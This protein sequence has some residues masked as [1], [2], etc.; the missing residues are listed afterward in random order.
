MSDFVATL[1]SARDS[2]AAVLHEFWTLYD[3]SKP[4]VHAFFEGH[5]DV[6]F[7]SHH[8]EKR[9]PSAM[10]LKTY[11]CNSKSRVF[12]AFDGIMRAIPDAKLTLFFVDKDLDD[13]LGRAW[14][15]DPRIF[16]TECYS[17][18]NYYVN[19]TVLLRIYRDSIKLTGCS[20]DEGVIAAHFEAEHARFQR[21]LLC[22]MAWILVA[23]RL[24]MAPNLGNL[25]TD[26]FCVLRP[27]GL[28]TSK[29]GR[30]EALEKHTGVRLGKGSLWRLRDALRE[31]ARSEPKR[32]IRGKFEMWFLVAFFNHTADQIRALADEIGAS[33][34]VR[35]RLS[36]ST[37][38]GAMP[39]HVDAPRALDLFL[40]AHLFVPVGEPPDGAPVRRQSGLSRFLARMFGH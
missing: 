27:D 15:T 23:R 37:T 32:V 24:G 9:L 10:R 26:H 21:K 13:V 22:V 17:I 33:A 30:V 29:R 3:P 36:L 40:R 11:R 7:F 4:R 2:R 6:S 35:C 8:I 19:E 25:T 14:P 18:E 5:D 20:F 38:V 31:L 1:R 34:K 28:I 16:V 12:E 39:H